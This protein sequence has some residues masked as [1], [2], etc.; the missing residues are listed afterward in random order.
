METK[1]TEA[2]DVDVEADNILKT[3]PKVSD[4]AGFRLTPIEFEKDDDTNFHM[5]FI[6]AASNLRA[7]NY[8]IEEVRFSLWLLPSVLFTRFMFTPD[9]FL[10][11][12][13]LFA[14][15]FASNEADRRQDHSRHRH[16]DR[17]RHWSGLYRN[18]QVVAEQAS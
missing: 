11:S 13:V 7:R 10:F 3:L 17:S 4:L 14:E 9:V 12:A 18:V 5:D 1:Q 8:K 2:M 15:R 16:D 6:T